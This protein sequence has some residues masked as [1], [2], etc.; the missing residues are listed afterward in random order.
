LALDASGVIVEV[1]MRGWRSTRSG[2]ISED[3]Q[4][5]EDLTIDD[6]LLLL[7]DY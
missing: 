2:A 5:D 4:S 6:V 1:T 3:C 7:R